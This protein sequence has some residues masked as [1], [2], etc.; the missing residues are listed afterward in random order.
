MS[1]IVGRESELELVDRFLTAIETSAHALHLHGE[2]G[3][4]KSTIWQRA[5]SDAGDRGYRVLSTRPTEVEAR[6]PFA[7]LNDLFGALFDELQSSLPDPQRVAMASALL[8]SPAADEARADPLA[9]PLGVLG[10]LRAAADRGPVLVAIDDIPWLDDSSAA[11][12]EFVVR[13]LDAEP[14]GIL[15]AER[16]SGD[17]SAREETRL[18]SA[19][20][21]ERLTEVR[22]APMSPADTDRLLGVVLGL[23]LAPS[24]LK[25]LHRASGGNPFYAVEIG[26][27]L[28]RR[29]GAGAAD[30]VPISDSLSSLLRDRLDA[31]SPA[32]SDVVEH[33]A[34]LSHPSTELLSAL[35]GSATVA[36]GVAEAADAKVITLDGDHIRFTHPLLAAEL[37][38][39]LGDAPRRIL[40]K[41]L[42]EVVSEP[43]E[44]AWHAALAADGP[45]EDVAAELERAAEQAHAR[46]APDAAADLVERALT[47][48]PGLA[49]QLHRRQMA[50]LY[51]LRA[52]DIVRARTA[53][54]DA[55][56]DAPTGEVRAGILLR[57]G[58]VREL[59][60]DWTAAEGLFDEALT[61]VGRDVRLEIAIRL[62]LAGVSH[63]TGRSWGAGARHVKE[64]M[65]LAESLGDGAVLA[66][67]IGP[68]V[69]WT[70]LTGPE[71]PAD[72]ESRAAELE[73]WTEGMRTLDHPDFDFGNISWSDGD[74]EGAR[75]FYLRLLERAE[76]IGDYSS[77]P[78]LLANLTRTDFLDGRAD[79]AFDR[80]DRAERLARTTG[81]RT[82][83][84]SVLA[85]RTR[86]LARLGH[87]DEAWSAGRELLALVAETGWIHG[88]PTV[89]RE[90]A[91]L[92][93]SRRA[94]EAALEVL[95][96]FGV[97]PGADDSPWVL[98]QAAPH[99][100]VLTALGRYSEARAIL[101]GWARLAPMRSS[102]TRMRHHLRVQALLEVAV[103]NVE[104]ASRLHAMAEEAVPPSRSRW[105]MAR[106]AL[107]A[108]EIHRRARR[109]AMA[110]DALVA[111]AEGFEFLG[112][113]L[114]AAL[115]REQLGRMVGAR[116]H[117]ERGLTPTQLQVA[118]LVTQGLSNR[119][120]GE[121]LF[122]SPHTVEAHLT[123]TYRALDIRSRAELAD[124]LHSRPPRD[125]ASEARDSSVISDPEP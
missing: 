17:R 14:I 42:A 58:E 60:D 101:D 99:A 124:A 89:R 105:W 76:R 70:H 25:R 56:N 121:R 95:E 94:P 117:D 91:L 64:A 26:R 16:T 109:R 97:P 13:R 84:G 20:P 39:G 22:V 74:V 51:H 61:Q 112:A 100:E 45:D 114:W 52:G 53:L 32:A 2:A 67:T 41:R 104:E 8:R 125:S 79:V 115:A 102:A 87:A 46:G 92:E 55:L 82:A 30:A 6:L 36:K 78:F 44:H 66:R 18:V 37:Y 47:L 24:S 31:L 48:T 12:L 4:G 35:L 19:M 27:A 75:R 33:A 3:V 59:M 90:L 1:T 106:L 28:Q 34:A 23:E 62:Q 49:E 9:I 107:V 83:L 11:A 113:R 80:L 43:E 77:I 123:A 93:M 120:V 103:G 57:L 5:M 50:A 69:T 108:A 110:R 54:E 40:H 65:R 118:E 29:G 98:W 71:V 72:L 21:A 122:M 96:P 85:H 10:L 63:I 86:L 88:E 68:F 73:P 81:Q 119:E 111:A 7:G 15:I 116:E 38:G